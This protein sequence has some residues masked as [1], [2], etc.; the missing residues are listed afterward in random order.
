MAFGK[1]HRFCTILMP[2]FPLFCSTYKKK[3]P[4]KRLIYRG[5]HFFAFYP[6]GERG[7]RTPGTSQFN[8]FQDRRNRPL[9]H[10]S[11]AFKALCFPSKAMQMYMFFLLLQTI[12]STFIS[13]F[14]NKLFINI[15]FANQH[16]N[17]YPM[18]RLRILNPQISYSHLFCIFVL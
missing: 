4:C 8:G 11:N 5:F 2:N 12:S 3:I 18:K 16:K 13:I 17:S 7:I 14:H 1:W 6:G 9:C 10:L 15:Y